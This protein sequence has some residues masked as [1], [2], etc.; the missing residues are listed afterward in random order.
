M[1]K[2][3]VPTDSNVTVRDFDPCPLTENSV[4]R[5]STTL[6]FR[7]VCRRPPGPAGSGPAS[8]L[9]SEGPAT[10]L[11]TMRRKHVAPQEDPVLW[12]TFWFVF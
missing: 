5:L 11:G 2:K 8:S 1:A 6:L 9:H 4:N 3:V 10:K 12:H 7:L